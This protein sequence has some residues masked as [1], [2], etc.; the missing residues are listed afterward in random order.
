MALNFLALQ[1]KLKLFNIHFF[2]YISRAQHRTWNTEGTQ[3][4]L[5]IGEDVYVYLHVFTLY[6]YVCINTFVSIYFHI[7]LQVTVNICM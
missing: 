6:E 3:V 1:H 7:F 5:F 4:Y 2:C